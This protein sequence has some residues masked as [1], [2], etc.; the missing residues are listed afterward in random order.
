MLTAAAARIRGQ[1]GTAPTLSDPDELPGG[2]VSAGSQQAN[3]AFVSAFTGRWSETL[4]HRHRHWG[5]ELLCARSNLDRCRSGAAGGPEEDEMRRLNAA[6]IPIYSSKV[7]MLVALDRRIAETLAVMD[8]DPASLLLPV[9]TPVR[10]GVPGL[11]K[12]ASDDAI[13]GLPA[14]GSAGVVVGYD[15]TA[16]WPMRVALPRDTRDTGGNLAFPYHVG[17][18][19]LFR[20]AADE[21]TVVGRGLLPGAGPNQTLGYVATHRHKNDQYFTEMLVEAEGRV[22]RLQVGHDGLPDLL[23][24]ADSE[25]EFPW[26]LRLDD[27]LPSPR[28]FR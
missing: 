27:A 3:A 5:H 14:A 23:S 18:L 9:G 4:R 21:L 6:C 13:S 22:W 17:H 1:H 16:E 7:A 19:R 12:L 15:S 25:D 24:A 2:Q 10:L 11:D 28:A 8:R 20:Y 26:L